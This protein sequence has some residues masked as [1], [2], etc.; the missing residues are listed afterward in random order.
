MDTLKDMV[1]ALIILTQ[2]ALALRFVICCVKE[3]NQEDQPQMYKKQRR[4]LLIAL[5]AIICVYDIPQILKGY[6]GGI[7]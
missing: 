5:I 1:D 7:G 6:F 4:M 3:T 2:S